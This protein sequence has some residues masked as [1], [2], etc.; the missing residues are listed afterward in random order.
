[1]ELAQL[2]SGRV[3]INTGPPILEHRL[4]TPCYPGT[5]ETLQ[6]LRLSKRGRVG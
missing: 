6:V 5:Q 4:L 1:M 3:D 2:A